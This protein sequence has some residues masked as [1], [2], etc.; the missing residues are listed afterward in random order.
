RPTNTAS[1]TRVAEAVPPARKLL[2]PGLHEVAPS[3]P[4]ARA[5]DR[6]PVAM[7]RPGDGATPH[8]S[9]SS[10]FQPTV[11]RRHAARPPAAHRLPWLDRGLT[12]IAGP[13]KPAGGRNVESRRPR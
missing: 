9:L 6:R 2:R 1:A 7:L 13:R 5:G 8:R 10:A 3:S 12:G 4:R 11:L